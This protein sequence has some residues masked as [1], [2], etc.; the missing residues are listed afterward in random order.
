MNRISNVS[1]LPVAE[2]LID[3]D[4]LIACYDDLNALWKK[5]EDDLATMRVCVP[6]KVRV[7]TEYG[8]Y[9][10]NGGNPEPSWSEVMFLG[11]RRLHKDWRICV[12]VRREDC[13]HPETDWV[14]K[15]LAEC[16][17]EDRIEC[18]AHFRAL[19]DEVAKAREKLIPKVIEAI[20]CLSESVAK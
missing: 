8:E 13:G 18:A 1:K 15:P 4:Q 6:V 17:V 3:R 7:K 5:A 20:A 12:G 19:K 9:I 2:K 10:C 14:W 11:W 16:S